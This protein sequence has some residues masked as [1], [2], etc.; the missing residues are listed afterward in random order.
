MHTCA[1]RGASRVRLGALGDRVRAPPEGLG[2]AYPASRGGAAVP[3]I[4]GV[5]PEELEPA[6]SFRSLSEET[7]AVLCDTW[8]PGQGGSSDLL[9]P[10][11][12]R[13]PTRLYFPELPGRPLGLG[14]L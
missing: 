9:P 12:P 5:A 7:W 8:P 1:E 11:W 4:W 10:L 3:R 2:T 13:V 14:G 6:S